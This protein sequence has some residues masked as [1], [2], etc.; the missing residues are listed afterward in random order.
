MKTGRET[1]DFEALRFD[2]V[3]AIKLDTFVPTTR[4]ARSEWA[5]HVARAIAERLVKGW[6][7][8]RKPGLP[9]VEPARVHGGMNSGRPGG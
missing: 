5:D 2:I 9:V 7:F 3:L 8:T 4:R 6:E 1:P